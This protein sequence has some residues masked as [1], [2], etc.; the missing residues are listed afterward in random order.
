MNRLWFPYDAGL[1]SNS[2]SD[3]EEKYIEEYALDVCGHWY[4]IGNR[5][6]NDA[7]VK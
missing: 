3:S 6:L 1:E 7:I 4:R 2:V 5:Q